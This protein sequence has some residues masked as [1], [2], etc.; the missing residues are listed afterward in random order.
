[1]TSKSEVHTM[2]AVEI[3]EVGKS[4]VIEVD[5]PAPGSGEV[6][7]QI[8]ANGIC[9]S[10]VAAYLGKH[11]YRVP[12][13]VTGHEPVGVVSALGE[14][15]D[16]FRRGEMV[17]V[18]PHAGCGECRECRSGR[19][20]VCRNKRVLGTPAW[21]GSFAEYIVAP[22]QCVY[23]VDGVLHE[24]QGALIEPLTVAMH[25]VRRAGLT[26]GEH[27]AVLGC[28]PIGLMHVL[29][30][31]EKNPRSLVCSDIKDYNLRLAEQIGA[32]HCFNPTR[33]DIAREVASLTGGEGLDVCFVV[34][35]SAELA[36]LAVDMA[37]PGGTIVLVASFP[38]PLPISFQRVQLSELRLVGTA[39]Y[40]REDYLHSIA[41][42]QSLGKRLTGLI[43]HRID[44][45]AV[46]EYLDL[47][48]RGALDEAV[49]VVIEM[50]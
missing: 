2:R 48:S 30:L 6:Q 12:P 4:K 5:R 10:D 31:G 50:H 15:A 44:L 21:P 19:Y 3:T 7:I 42:A 1:M 16:G 14:G 18:E 11:P 36:Q 39:M 32:T 49:K 17:V 28:G 26:G 24:E 40:T 23:S 47:L 22:V 33:D 25:S 9:G 45:A 43:T 27:A 35:H 41:Y 34:F 37:K 20:N 13:V 29:A 8:L 46:P 38:S